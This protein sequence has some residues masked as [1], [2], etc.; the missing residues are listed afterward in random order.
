MLG[1]NGKKP[2]NYNK[3]PGK[4]VKFGGNMVGKRIRTGCFIA[5]GGLETK[6]QYIKIG[7]LYPEPDLPTK[8]YITQGIIDPTHPKPTEYFSTRLNN[9]Y[10]YFS[11]MVGLFLAAREYGVIT[12]TKPQYIYTEL[13]KRLDTAFKTGHYDSQIKYFKRK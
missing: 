8:I 4:T 11:Y 12:G 10:E 2:E 5:K 7:V 13:V 9:L 6:E 3:N 1:K